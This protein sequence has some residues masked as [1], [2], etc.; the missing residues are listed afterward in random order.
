MSSLLA[1]LID[2]VM[3]AAWLFTI[4]V[5]LTLIYGVMKILN[6]AHGS[7]YA[8]GAYCC[9]TALGQYFA[10][11]LPPMGA[12]LAIFMSALIG[13]ILLG[14]IV[15]RGILRLFGGRDPIVMLLV[16]YA[17]F[18]VLEDAIK[19]IWGV[20]PYIVG[21]PLGLLG[22][23]KIGTLVYPGY[24][25]LVVVVAV[26][27]CVV[28]TSF[29]QQ[30]AYGKILRA[31]IHDPEV[32]STLG[33]NVTRW[34]LV[35]FITGSVLAALGGA[36]TAPTISVVPGMAVEVVVM[37]FAVVVIGG[38][39]SIPGTIIGALVVG[40]VRSAAVHFWPEVELFSIYAVMALVLVVKPKGLFA[41]MELR[42]I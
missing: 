39:G 16:T 38:L 6:M 18:L 8:F 42:K 7:F 21:E 15:E 27:V 41:G 36:L 23:V 22:V 24:N 31:V 28:L 29:L 4:A 35:A 13:G 12:F 11:G 34:S 14:L 20:D 26:L 1:V 32:S 40:L 17:L 25:F 2:G 33:I 9:A 5:G 37:M 30:T 3:H 19:L 10:A